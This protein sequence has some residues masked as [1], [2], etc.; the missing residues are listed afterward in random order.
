MRQ[1]EKPE[2][3]ITEFELPGDVAVAATDSSVF[4]PP[5]FDF[6]SNDEIFLGEVEGYI[7]D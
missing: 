1:Y 6:N 7:V 3:E 2:L 4:D 5:W